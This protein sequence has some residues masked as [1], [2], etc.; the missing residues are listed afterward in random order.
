[1]ILKLLACVGREMGKG[2]Y[3]KGEQMYMWFG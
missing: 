3:A 1:M 2:G